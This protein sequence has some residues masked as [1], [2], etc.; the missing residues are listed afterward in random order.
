MEIHKW[1]KGCICDGGPEGPELEEL[2]NMKKEGGL[3]YFVISI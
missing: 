2:S 1:H 3:S